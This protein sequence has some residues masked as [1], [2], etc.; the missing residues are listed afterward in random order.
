MKKFFQGNLENEWV[1]WN[2]LVN[3]W[4]MYMKKKSTWIRVNEMKEKKEEIE[5]SSCF[6]FQFIG[7]NSFG[8]TNSFSSIIM[9]MF[10]KS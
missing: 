3:Q 7:F 4:P 2:K 5:H 8:C 1:V 9:A 6:V 10:D